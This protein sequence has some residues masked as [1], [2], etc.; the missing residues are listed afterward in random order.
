LG[1]LFIGHEVAR[2][3]ALR[4]IFVEKNVA[5]KLE[6]RRSFQIAP[7]EKFLV[8]EDVVTKGGRVQE[9]MEI[10]RQRGGE[11][12]AV[13]TLVDRSGGKLDFGVPLESLIQFDIQTF[14]P[15]DCPMCK[16]GVPVIK[17]GS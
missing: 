5:G 10:L 14:E 6:L 17:P 1:G 8:V 4:H 9:T 12:A 13:G 3:L 15:S 7:R 2:A 16:A 11:V